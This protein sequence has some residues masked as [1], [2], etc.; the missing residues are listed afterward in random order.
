MIKTITK[1]SEL[2]ALEKACTETEWLRNLLAD[3]PIGVKPPTS[4]YIHCNC[5]AA[6][7][8]AKSKIY[9]G[10]SKY[11]R[12]R[13]NIIKQMLESEVESL[14]YVKSELNF[15]DPLTKPLNRRK[16]VDTLRR[17]GLMPRA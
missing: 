17:M 1:E 13:Y 16:V 3:L 6:I 2:I 12:L 15:A 11:I 9:N 4:I 5:Q 10:K 14:N 7:A 8:K